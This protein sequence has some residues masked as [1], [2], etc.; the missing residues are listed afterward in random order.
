MGRAGPCVGQGTSAWPLKLGDQGLGDVC[1]DVNGRARDVVCRLVVEDGSPVAS[2]TCLS[3][4]LCVPVR[5]ALPVRV[6]RAACA[7]SRACVCLRPLP[8]LPALLGFGVGLR[9]LP[10]SLRIVH[11]RTG[12]LLGISCVCVWGAG[13]VLQA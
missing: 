2:G 11:L 7:R 12:V 9:G 5:T 6:R 1:V 10:E 4:E 13:E 8:C 3:Q